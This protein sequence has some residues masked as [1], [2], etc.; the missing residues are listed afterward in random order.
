MK[1]TSV[2]AIYFLIFCFSAFLTLPFGVKTA[3]EAGVEKVPG[4]SESAPHR[5]DLP[6]HLVRAAVIALALTAL[7]VANYMFGWITVE[8]LDFYN[9]G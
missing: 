1:W 8:D 5:F 3:E 2:L 9:Q 6:R 4:Q 7:Y